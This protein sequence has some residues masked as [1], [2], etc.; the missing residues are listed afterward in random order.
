MVLEGEGGQEGPQG[1]EAVGEAAARRKVLPLST[2]MVEA[3][4]A[5][6]EAEEML[7]VTPAQS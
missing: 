7:G 1:A 5:E 4:G 6:E 3:E 2:D